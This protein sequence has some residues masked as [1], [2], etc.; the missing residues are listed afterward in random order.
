MEETPKLSPSIAKKLLDGTPLAAWCDHRLLGNLRKPMT[1][2]QR[3][4]ILAHAAILGDSEDVAVL[5]F[6]AFRS[7][8]AKEARDAAIEEGKIPVTEKAWTEIT[9][10]TP[11]IRQSLENSGV[12]FGGAVEQKLSWEEDGV[13]CTGVLDHWDGKVLVD[14][15]KSGPAIPTR[16]YCERHLVQSHSHL[17]DPAYRNAVA[18]EI[19]CDPEEITVRFAF[20]QTQAP[21]ACY[22]QPLSGAARE[23]AAIRWRRAVDIWRRCLSTGDWYGP[24]AED[25]PFDVPVWALKREMEMEAY[26]AD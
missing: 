20:V 3:A 16:E 19:D 4:G 15:I 12:V 26:D 2:G 6:D 8:D 7:K 25:M 21:F 22:V 14:E 9:E 11:Q 10:N 24:S 17:Q 23:Y 13:L 18:S 1:D 5:P